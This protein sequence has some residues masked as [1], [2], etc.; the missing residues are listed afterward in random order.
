MPYIGRF[1]P[2]PSGGLH[3]GSLVAALASYLDAKAQQ[4]IWLMRFEDIDPP[5]EVKGGA[6]RII[7]ALQAHGIQTDQPM[8]YQSQRLAFYWRALQCLVQQNQVYSCVCSNKLIKQ[9]RQQH[10]DC[11]CCQS[12]LSGQPIAF[13][14]GQ[15]AYRVHVPKSLS[16]DFKDRFVGNLCR[17]TSQ[18]PIDEVD[19]FVI[20]R[21]DGLVAYQLAVVVDDYQQG[22]THVVRGQDLFAIT[23]RQLYLQ[24]LLGYPSPSYAHVPLLR[25]E[26]GYKLSKQNRSP[27]L[28]PRNP[29][30]N[31]Q[32]A[33]SHLGLTIQ[34]AMSLPAFFRQAT[35]LWRSRYRLQ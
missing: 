13:M 15:T 22:V 35:A 6:V 5:R 28:D 2:S 1:A 30:A 32:F 11:P 16:F 9:Y 21:R 23:P 12:W 20:W 19:D 27:V 26:R 31:L 14:L 3:L 7:E 18:L 24:R 25:D 29:L 34:Q 4:G 33:A 10:R 8:V 17:C